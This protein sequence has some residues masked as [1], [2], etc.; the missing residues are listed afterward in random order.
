M[1]LQSMI[2]PI[3]TLL[4]SAGLTQA[5]AAMGGLGKT[6]DGLAKNIGA[7]AASFAGFQALAGSREFILESVDATQRLERNL[8]ALGQVYGNLTPQLKRFGE[9]IDSYGISQN[10]SAQASIFIGSVLK[11]YGFNVSE[12]ADATQRIVMLSQDLATTYGYD[13]QEALLAVT[14][15]FRGEFDPIEKFGV[16]M[17]QNEINAELAARGLEDLEGAARENAEAQ[18]TLDFLFTRAADSVGAFSRATD[19]LYAS[20]KRLQAQI[21]NLQAAFGEPFQK[22][23]AEL[24]N[25]FAKLIEDNAP[26]LLEVSDKLGEGLEALSPFIIQ[27][28]ENILKLAQLTQPLIELLTSLV[29]IIRPILLPIVDAFGKGLDILINLFDAL[30]ATVTAGIKILRD[31]ADNNPVLKFFGD[32][33]KFLGAGMFG[34]LD[35]FINSFDEGLQRA[36]DNARGFTGDIQGFDAGAKAASVALRA[37]ALASRDDAKASAEAAEEQKKLAESLRQLAGD[38]RDAE[39]NLTGLAKIFADVDEAAEKSKAKDALAEIGIEASAIEEILTQP[40]WQEIFENIAKYARL[41]AIDITKVSYA[42]AVGISNQ[43]MAIEEFIANAFGDGGNGTQATDFVGDFFDNIDDAIAKESARRRLQG[44]GAS[45]GLIEAILGA[46]G[47]Q[48]VFKDVI[49]D[50][51]EGLKELQDEFNKTADGIREV[52]EA[53]EELAK[54][55]AEA[56]EAATKEAQKYIDDLQREADRLQA[57]YEAAR[58][59]ADSFLEKLQDFNTISILPDYEA[60]L[61]RF[62][63]A[64][65]GSIERMRSE[66]KSAFRSDLILQSD[67]D[68]LMQWVTTEEELLRRIAKQR[69]DLANRYALSE[70]LINDYRRA[71]TGAFNLTSLFGKLKSETEKRTVTE[72]SKGIVELENGLK[73]FAVTVTRSYEETVDVTQDKTKGLL[74]GFREM[75]AKARGFAENLQKLK[76]LGLDSMLFNQLVEAGVEAGGETA[77]ALVDGGSETITEIN[78]LFQ[79]IDD[80]GKDLGEQVAETMYGAGIDMSMGLLDGIASERERLL[81]LARDMADAFNA[82]FTSRVSTALEKPVEQAFKAAEAAEAAVPAIEDI[83]IAGLAQLNEYL[84]NAGEALQ[85]VSSEAVKTGIGVKIGVVESLKQDV[86]AGMRFDLGGIVRGLSSADLTAAAL[87]T[88]S[89]TVNNTYN[90]TVQASGNKAT[91]YSEGLAFADGLTA[92]VE[93][94]PSLSLQFT[95]AN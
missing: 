27:V 69:D 92:A 18:I 36:R 89:P 79:E 14:A 42:A 73:E 11:Q 13:V 67:F 31:F 45:E 48:K 9:E 53:A 55:Q 30:S 64:V 78:S 7:A 68:N 43:M 32:A 5:R 51:V 65:V 90:V 85:K 47:W 12:A 91:A 4:R 95:G 76:A 61:G 2:I 58:L 24:N 83:D 56:L 8:I 54:A 82:E 62:E 22:P 50:G 1:A 81:E 34:K 86:L 16:A 88:G 84:R 33:A 28:G 40:N 63:T 74:D 46:A 94:N 52:T 57:I 15:L 29:D 87:A 23:L 60:E 66:L 6:F 25:A 35:S 26:G 72:V 80:I 93:S 39:G 75:A 10:Q 20:Q 70:A 41:A 37:K 77:Q 17:K 21:A 49:K 19:T 44:M 71:L 59:K 3:V 38:T